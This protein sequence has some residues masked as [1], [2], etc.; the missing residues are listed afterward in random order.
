MLQGF[1]NLAAQVLGPKPASQNTPP[2]SSGWPEAGIHKG[3]ATAC[4]QLGRCSQLHP[5]ITP[6]HGM[7][8]RPDRPF[9]SD[10]LHHL[11]IQQPD[12]PGDS[13]L[14]CQ[15]CQAL[16]AHPASP[17]AHRDYYLTLAFPACVSPEDYRLGSSAMLI[18]L[19]VWGP[20][21]HCSSVGLFSQGPSED[22]YKPCCSDSLELEG[23]L[24]WSF[25]CSPFSH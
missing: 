5:A 16:R 12:V 20:G 3:G 9:L 7:R 13:G 23:G 21:A 10:L 24:L 22:L 2:K 1:W 25:I 6:T 11:S 18:Q 14:P 15:M 17:R 4:R 8:T 19:K